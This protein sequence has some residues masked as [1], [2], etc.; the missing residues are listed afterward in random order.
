MNALIPG[1]LTGLSLI[2]AIGAQ[3]AYVIRQGLAR[4]NV[5]LVVL[6]CAL[7][8]ALLIVLGAS[9]LGALIQA[10]PDLLELIR[11][12]GVIY[13]SWFGIKS[14]RSAMKSQSLEIGE[15][16]SRENRT[17]KRKVVATVFALTYLNPHVYLDT[18]IFLGSIA[19]QFTEDKWFFVTGAALGSF[20][21]FF[22]IGF[23]AKKASRFMS[24]PI[25]WK[26]LDF[27]IA[28]VMFTVAI[29]LA[30]YSF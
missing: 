2:I 8:D 6:F 18:V 7:S 14:L 13:L 26:I 10:A 25:F 22:T 23:G 4:D 11:W 28:A 17:S 30:L 24:R 1:L 3:N 12:F 19:N 5:L 16:V 27:I 20:L 15:N 21:W 29:I 9:G